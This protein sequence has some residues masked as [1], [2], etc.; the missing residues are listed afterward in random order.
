MVMRGGLG[1]GKIAFAFVGITVKR[2][3]GETL[4]IPGKELYQGRY[5]REI[6]GKQTQ[7]TEQKGSL[8]VGL[9]W[10]GPTRK[11][12]GQ[13]PMIFNTQSCVAEEWYDHKG[14]KAGLLI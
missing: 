4:D 10:G 2:F 13:V 14:Y 9:S 5:I 12:L 11:G 7:R 3:H 1:F 8:N 6:Q